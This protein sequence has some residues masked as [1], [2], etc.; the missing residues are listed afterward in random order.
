MPTCARPVALAL[1]S[2][3][4]VM[5]I[6]ARASEPPGGETP[7]AVVARLEKAMADQDLAEMLACVTPSSR[8]EASLMLVAGA[9]MMVAF[10]AMGSAMGAEMA[11]GF[12]AG[13]DGE[14][15]AEEKAKLEEQKRAAEAKAAELQARYEGILE[16][17][18]VTAM[19]DD[20][21]PLPEDPAARR[22]ELDRLFADTDDIALIRDLLAML[23]D[24]GEGEG[25]G[26]SPR[27]PVN[28]P[29]AV[30]DYVVEGDTAT[31]R[32]GDETIHFQRVGG[33]WYVEPEAPGAPEETAAPEAA[34]TSGP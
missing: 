29:G 1:S 34:A 12:A 4:L 2:L 33:R 27:S 7:Q 6:A 10:M 11:E 15:P 9:G 23:E 8:R 16:R 26:G 24:L 3:L 5:P 19:M 22:A 14:V 31:A 28:L 32:S 20:E 18:G 17:H 13:E 21:T 25:G 30:T